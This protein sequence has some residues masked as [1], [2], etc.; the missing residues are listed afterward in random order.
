MHEVG[1]WPKELFNNLDKA[2]EVDWGGAVV[3]SSKQPSP[4]MGSGHF[5]S[6]GKNKSA[7]FTNIQL[8]NEKNEF[9]NPEDY[10]V[11][12]DTDRP[13]YYGIE[14]N[15]YSGDPDGYQFRYG[16]PGEI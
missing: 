5:P 14:G 8:V 2:T 3:H 4:P 13:D 1:Y 11:T 7:Y 9:Y 16:G 6:E 10:R 12:Q 15:Y